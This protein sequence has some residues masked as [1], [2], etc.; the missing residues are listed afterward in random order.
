MNLWNEETLLVISTDFCHYGPRFS[1]NLFKNDISTKIKELDHLGMKA[2]NEGLDQFI[3]YLNE[4]GN[5]ICGSNPLKL[6]LRMKE[7]KKID[8]KIDWIDYEQ[9]NA[10]ASNRDSSVSY[11]AGLLYALKS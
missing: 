3:K 10:I 2:L 4:T 8:H 6:F 11:A 5:T 9:S 7:L 1:F